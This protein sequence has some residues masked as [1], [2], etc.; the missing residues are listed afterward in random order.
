MK[1]LT[2]LTL[3]VTSAAWAQGPSAGKILDQQLGML[4]GEFVPLAEAMPA[5]KYPFAPAQG[6]FK[7]VRTFALQVSHVAAVMYSVAAAALGEKNPTDMGSNENGPATLKTKDDIVKYL[8]DSFAYAHK[9]MQSITDQNASAMVDSPFGGNKVP[10]MSIANVA[11][12]H[13]FDHYGQMAVYARMCG[14]VP[15]ASRR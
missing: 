1:R 4:E 5:D 7:G 3:L 6:E 15:P 2:L 12:W 14:V 10:R 13:G 9:A 8:K 11:V